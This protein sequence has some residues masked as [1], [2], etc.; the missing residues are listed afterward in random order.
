MKVLTVFAHPNP[1]SFCA[2]VLE[3]FTKGLTDAGHVS[4]VVDLHAIRFDPVFRT[5]DFANYVTEDLPADVLER[6]DLKKYVLDAARG[7]F[8][9]FLAA[10][11]LRGKS[12]AGVVRLIRTRRPKDVAAQQQ[13]VAWADGLAFIAP[14]MWI[15]FPAMLRGWFERVFTLGFAYDLRPE[16]WRGDLAGRVPL[17]RHEKALIISTTLF[18]AAA[19]AGPIGSAMKT[20]MDDFALRYPGV[21]S[22]EHVYFHSVPAVDAATRQGYLEQAYRLGREFAEPSRPARHSPA[23]A[24]SVAS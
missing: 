15:G 17:L 3:R 2:A 11:W 12:V 23:A 9:R 16:G 22:V 1:A 13:M 24:A 5:E 6:M 18:D 10:R 4:K 14:V 7:R 8:Q 20:M 21:K 19:Y